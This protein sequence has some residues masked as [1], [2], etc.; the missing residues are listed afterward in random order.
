MIDSKTLGT[1]LT[2]VA[3]ALFLTACGGGS[4]SG[5]VSSGDSDSASDT[6][7][8]T[9]SATCD[10]PITALSGAFLE[11][12]A[13]PNVDTVLSADG[14]TVSFESDG[15]PDHSS[16]YW[17]PEGSSGLWVA[18]LYPDVFGDPDPDNHSGQS[19]PGY[20]DDYVNDYDLTVPVK[21]EL[22]TSTSST[23]L[24]AIGI[25]LSGTPI[26]NDQEGTGDLSTG[27]AQ[28]LDYS[29]AHT[30]PETYHYHLEP[31]AISYDDDGL[32][33]I[34]SDG[35]FIYGRKCYSTG[36]YPTDLDESNG[37]I[38]ITQHTGADPE[39]AEY[40]Y[41]IDQDPYLS[42]D[43]YL[44]FPGDYQGTPNAIR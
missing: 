44:I 13:A 39:N 15:K 17:D 14:C 37:H 41:H 21:A 30:G 24:G 40:H 31:R 25:A 9:S 6:D 42:G 7:G 29:G 22:A 27:V 34:I 38:S 35:F 1:L 36:D 28:G 5:G 23:S 19:S 26:F 16:P 32:V 2:G 3:A 8:S 12:V 33:G 18:P 4:S 10:E 43:Y 20:I 11:F